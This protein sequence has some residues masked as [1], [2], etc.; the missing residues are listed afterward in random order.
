MLYTLNSTGRFW[1][2]SINWLNKTERKPKPSTCEQPAKSRKGQSKRNSPQWGRA[3]LTLRW[4]STHREK[5]KF[6][7]SPAQQDKSKGADELLCISLCL[8]SK[9]PCWNLG[10]WVVWGF[11]GGWGWKESCFRSLLL[12]LFIFLPLKTETCVAMGLQMPAS[13]LKVCQ[14]LGSSL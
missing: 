4:E 9:D 7:T 10:G 1:I 12:F 14:E 13:G 3:G 2:K 11:L 8:L 5:G 6:S